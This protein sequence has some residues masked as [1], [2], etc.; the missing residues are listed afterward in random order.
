MQLAYLVPFVVIVRLRCCTF[1]GVASTT[2]EGE[3]NQSILHVQTDE[4]RVWIVTRVEHYAVRR[5]SLELETK[6]RAGRE[7]KFYRY[8][9]NQSN[10]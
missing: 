3:I 10:D 9:V 8:F 1:G 7:Q 5:L 2:V 6:L 4:A